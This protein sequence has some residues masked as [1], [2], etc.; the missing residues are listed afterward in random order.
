MDFIRGLITGVLSTLVVSILFYIMTPIRKRFKEIWQYY[1]RFKKTGL[2]LFVALAEFTPLKIVDKMIDEA[3]GGDEILIVGRT[4]RWLTDKR[5]EIMEGLKNGSNL[6]ILILNPQKVQDNVIDLTPLQ[7]KDPQTIDRDLQTSMSRFIS[8]CDEALSKNYDGS[9]EVRICDFVI[10]NSLICFTHERGRFSKRKIILDFSFSDIHP[11]DKY[12]QYYESDPADCGHFC[13]KLYNFYKGFY[14]RSQFYIRYYRGKIERS[15]G[16]VKRFIKDDVNIL[17]QKYSESEET[18]NNEPANYIL[19]IPQMFES[20]RNNNPPPY[21][22]SVQLELTNSCNAKCT[23]CKRH[24]WPAVDEMSTGKIEKLL[25]ELVRLRVQSIT[26]SGGEPTLRPDFI[27]ILEYA[28]NQLLKVGVLTNGLDINYNL[29]DAIIRY[30]DWVRISLDEIDSDKYLRVRG[31]KGGFQNVIESIKNLEKAKRVNNRNCRIGICY[32]IQR[33]NIKDVVQ[34]IECAK[35]LNLSTKEKALTFKF[36]HGRN[37][38]LCNRPQLYDFYQDVLARDDP[39][40]N[41]MTNLKYLKNFIDSYSN[42]EDIVSGLP[43]NS[44]YKMNKIRCFTPYVFSLIDASG[45]VYPCCFLY[46]DNDVYERFKIERKKYRMGTVSGAEPFRQIWLGKRYT[47][48]R[49]A[50]RIIDVDKLPECKECTRH[51]LHNAFLT[52]FFA[53]YDSYITELGDEGKT[54]LQQV[55]VQYQPKTVWL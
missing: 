15:Q 20:I 46:Y 29:A 45:D 36:V 17:V 40:W 12:Q 55:L 42:I 41:K 10:F 38:F 35:K 37:G 50:L 32:S 14:D 7:L 34:M 11:T 24:T 43:L 21:P 53:K 27:R 13:D 18:R 54:L 30:S 6:K 33:A 8:I 23:H 49:N 47:G 2:R 22:I 48:I 28:H 25:R 51:Y 1:K 31:V 4:L 44:Y 5:S 16:F 26:L 52:E 39:D 3:K 9:F 19:A